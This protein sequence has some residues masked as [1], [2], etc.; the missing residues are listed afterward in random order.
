MNKTIGQVHGSALAVRALAGLALLSVLHVRAEAPPPALEWVK[1]SY[2]GTSSNDNFEGVAVGPDGCLY[3]AGNAGTHLR[4]LPGGVSPTQ[5]GADETASRCGCG[6]V[7]KLSPDAS[8]ILACAEFGMG[9]LHATAVAVTDQG[10]YVG[11]Y[12]S[13]ALEPLLK[14]RQ[15]WKTAYPLRTEQKRI[16]E[17]TMQEANGFAADKPD[18]LQNR[19][20]LGRLGAPCVL[21]LSMDLKTLENGTYLEG[22]EQVYDKNRK[23][24]RQKGRYQEFFWQPIDIC[25]L[26]SGDVVV[27]HD[28][29]YFRML[30]DSDRALAARLENPADRA[31]LLERLA[32]YDVPDYVSRLTGDL[33]R[34]VWRTDIYTPLTAT[35]VAATVKK[36]WTL[37]HYGNSRTH[38]MRM[39]R[40]ENLWVCG[41]SAAETCNEPWWSPFL[42]KLDPKT[43]APTRKLY[44]Y[45]PMGG[46][47]HRM[48]GDVADTA[49]L[50]VAVE[51]SGNLL[52]CLIADG[53]NS[54]MRRGPRGN[55]GRSMLGPIVGPGLG[56]SPA[57]FW[58]Q[59]QR[60]DGKT[61]DGLG[62]ASSGPWGWTIDVAGLPD[63]N[64]LAIGRWNAQLPWTPNAWWTNSVV[65]NPNAFLR[66]V[67]P[68]YNT[69]F[70]T[71]LPGMRP[72]EAMPIGGDRI[73][74]AGFATAGAAPE[75]DS[76]EPPAP[77]G[78][79]AYFAIVKWKNI[80]RSPY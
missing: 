36:G 19:P 47:D 16:R 48:N 72:F 78:E 60:V 76:L 44:E 61:Y 35:N 39:D 17:G 73:L 21:R 51:D 5:F 56:G 9:M 34:R 33:T 28:G 14:D 57:H 69:V 38:R 54:V 13:D 59:A 2:F 37:P 64:F 43:G 31:K 49:L 65:N 52:T 62:G 80:T 53:G 11:G 68:D 8:K 45:D 41:W 4:A 67:G 24:G 7:L 32:F 3:L 66:V 12:A 6:F 42:W 55:E 27:S 26:K 22:W 58:G 20:W 18:S 1:A 79:D 29:G 10:V 15:G 40:E 77:A 46:E 25:P 23:C 71:A 50:S 74:V 30:T 70:W 63:G 75:K